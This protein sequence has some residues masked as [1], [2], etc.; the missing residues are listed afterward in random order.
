MKTKILGIAPYEGMQV[1]MKQIAA[2]RD[3]IDL[4]VVVGDLE[5]G[6]ELARKYEKEDF[7]VIISRG[8]TAELIRK[9]SSLPV[10]E[11]TITIYDILRALKLAENYTSKYAMVGFPSITKDAQFLSSLLQ[12][13]IDIYTIHNEAEG[14]DIL[15]HL[16]QEGYQMVLCDM[17]TNSLSKHFGLTSILITS[18]TESIQEAF[19]HAL[20]T[21]SD[22]KQY[23][24][25][26]DFY[27]SILE[28]N[29]GYIFVFNEQEE[30]VYF[31]KNY[32]FS[33]KVIDEMRKR[34]PE[35]SV[36]GT[37]KYYHEDDGLILAINGTCK[38]I[39][40][41]T[42]IIYYVN[43]RKVPLALT[44]NGIRYINKEEA[45]DRFFNSFYGITHSSHNIQMSIQEYAESP[46]PM[47][48]LG[49]GGTGKD[50]MA[51]LL[52]F[53]SPLSC[54]PL[55][56]ID[57]ARINTKGWSFL[58]EHNNS[59]LSDTNTTIYIRSLEV[60]PENQFHELFSI[61]RDLN[62][63]KRN[64]MLF[65]FSYDDDGN[66]TD[67][68]K[69]I[70][71]HYSCLT[72]HIPP[73]RKHLYEIPN[74]VSLYIN[75]LNVQLAKEIIG[76]DPKAM[77]LLQNYDWPGNYNQFK[78][79]LNELVTIT[80][81]PYIQQETVAGILRKENT[82]FV[83]SIRDLPFDLSKTMEEM[84]LEIAQRVLAEENGHQAATALRLGISRSTLWRMLQKI[85]QI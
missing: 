18:G 69:Q 1:L 6:A 54:N 63:Y 7:D 57:C 3:D 17:I 66:I 59:P 10:I 45:F 38:V 75:S 53:K 56:I 9:T 16:S 5:I 81:T 76:L 27:K 33:K 78:R 40:T 35:L 37:R 77:E 64:R 72:M 42:Y 41:K 32:S 44:K 46:N 4:T 39:N 21:V 2:Q 50:Q 62:L 24:F 65:T 48:I 79:I 68:C 67:R 20:K 85:Q 31:N 22:H 15:S 73:L 8:G 12:Y 19:S 28:E 83:S 34:I 49:E 60:L 11:V 43:P 58:T 82:H 55:A 23:A 29:T 13:D 71:N 30:M 47:M 26:T 74:L 70:I 51:R 80:T 84:N 25:Q 36:S 61:I 14:S 52:Y